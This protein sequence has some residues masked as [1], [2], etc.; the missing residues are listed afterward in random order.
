MMFVKWRF[1]ERKVTFSPS[2]VG[3][4]VAEKGKICMSWR[5]DLSDVSAKKT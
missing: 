3:K 2:P 5:T 1:T 4:V